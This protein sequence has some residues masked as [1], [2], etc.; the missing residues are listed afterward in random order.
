MT[1]LTGPAATKMDALKQ[2]EA[3]IAALADDRDV[4][5]QQA[6]SKLALALRR[7]TEVL[8]YGEARTQAGARHHE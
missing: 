7:L 5:A 4:R 6:S 2:M 3:E 1:K 8:I